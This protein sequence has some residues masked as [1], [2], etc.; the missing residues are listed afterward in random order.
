[1]AEQI[2]NEILAVVLGVLLGPLGIIYV[3][4][5]WA[6]ISACVSI[7]FALFASNLVPILWIANGALAY[8]LANRINKGEKI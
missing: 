8:S 4:G 5:K 1:M 7:L 6:A 2:K 3:S